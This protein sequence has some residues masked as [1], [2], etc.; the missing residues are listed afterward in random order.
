MIA[1][2]EIG[3][4]LRPLDDFAR[5]HEQT[6]RRWG[7]GAI[8]MSYPNPLVYRDPR[9]HRLLADTAAAMS[10]DRLQYTPFGGTT[11]V[12]RKSAAALSRRTGLRYGYRDIALTPGATAA[13]HIAISALFQPD[14][15][16]LLVTPC[17]MDYPVYIR[18]HGLRYRMVPSG[19][20]KRLDVTAIAQAWGA[21][22]A[23]L[24]ISQ[25]SCPTGVLY[26][27]DELAELAAALSAAGR[28]RA[29]PPVLISDEVHSHQNWG[30]G[31]FISPATVYPDTAT[32]YSFGKAW[33][34]QGQRTGYLALS[35]RLRA[36]DHLTA[37]VEQRLRVSGFCAPTALMQQVAGQLSE[38]EPDFG[39]LGA[40]QARLRTRMAELGYAVTPAHGTTFLYARS[41]HPDEVAFTTHLALEHG[42]IA[43]PSSVFH[44]PGHF[45]LALNVTG[46]RLDEAAARLGGARQTIMS[47]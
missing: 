37:A 1:T 33:S 4:L 32:I 43:M 41:P 23:G 3:T 40:D 26:S 28:G 6:L 22:T 24:I 12:R 30:G 35:P 42:L 19:D 15:E 5:V 31:D 11:L 16:L 25:P 44:E 29:R 18:E 47:R 7:P 21:D 45:R 36:H 10:P 14:D 17:W 2:D 38:L 13:L 27:A 20:D 34:M 39:S 46:D 8:D 9:A